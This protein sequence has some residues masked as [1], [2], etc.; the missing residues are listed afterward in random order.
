[1]RV[2][3]VRSAILR[4]QASDHTQRLATAVAIDK[5]RRFQT[6]LSVCKHHHNLRLK[7][8][9]VLHDLDRTLDKGMGLVRLNA[10]LPKGGAAVGH[11]SKLSAP[12]SS[13]ASAAQAIPFIGGDALDT[14]KPTN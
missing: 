12:A 10:G 13:H 8:P 3:N 6:S 14:S 11:F 2:N 5:G 7:A 1:V 9:E 4:H